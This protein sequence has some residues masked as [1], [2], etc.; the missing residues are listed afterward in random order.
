VKS[1]KEVMYGILKMIPENGLRKTEIKANFRSTFA[2]PT[3]PPGCGS[4]FTVTLRN[5]H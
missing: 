3:P 4:T 5:C 2:H 1:M